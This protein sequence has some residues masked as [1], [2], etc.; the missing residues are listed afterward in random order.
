LLRLRLSRTGRRNQPKYRLVVAE[1]SEKLDGKVVA[2]VGYYI[3]TGV[4]KILKIDKEAVTGW[5]AK[6]VIASNTVAK[7]LNTQGFSLPVEMAPVRPAKKAPKEEPVKAPSAEPLA[8]GEEKVEE[9]AE[10]VVKEEEVAEPTPAEE[11]P[12]EEAPA[13]EAAPVVE[14]TPVEPASASEEASS[15]E[16]PTAE[17]APETGS[18]E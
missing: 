2:T 15:G 17:P 9:A 7:L 8:T 14:E 18:G 1:K 5:L 3:P 4:E 10:E 6:G 16:Q 13:E 12:A 11:A